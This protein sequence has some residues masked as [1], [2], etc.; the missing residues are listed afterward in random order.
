MYE[1]SIPRILSEREIT[2]LQKRNSD[3]QELKFS[4]AIFEIHHDKLSYPLSSSTHW[5][6]KKEMTKYTSK[7]CL[8][9]H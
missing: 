3:A 5:K 2:A 7:V 4:S 6:Q 8:K 1:L 9:S